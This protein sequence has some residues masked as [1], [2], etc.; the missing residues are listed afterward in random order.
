MP[1]RKIMAHVAGGMV[2]A[3]GAGSMSS[4]HAQATPNDVKAD[5]QFIR[6]VASTNLLEIQLGKLAQKKATNSAVK[7]FAQRM[8]VDHTQL[9]L[10]WVN[11]V[12]QNGMIFQPGITAAQQQEATQLQAVS[13][14]EFDRAYMSS[15]IQG[16]Q[17]A[18]SALQSGSQAAHSSV[19]RALATSALTTVQQHLSMASQVGSQVG[20]TSVATAT[21]NPTV[22][23]TNPNGPTTNPT[24]PTTNPTGP[25]TTPTVPT[26][27]PTVPT[28][29]PAGQATTNGQVATPADLKEDSKF[30]FDQ[31]QANLME[32]RL[33]Q[34]A[35]N[36]AKTPAVKRLAERLVAD[37]G[38]MQN[39]WLD[40]TSRNGAPIKPSMGKL[41]WQKVNRL[42]DASSK[43]F[44]RVYLSLVAEN[45][46]AVMNYLLKEGRA[47]HSAQVRSLVESDIPT[48]RGDM[49][50][51]EQT[52]N[53]MGLDINNKG[54][55]SINSGGKVKA[56][57]K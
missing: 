41:H 57:S 40:M 39:E 44:D 36:R 34:M 43:E 33:G 46:Q 30:I 38:R 29:N 10:Q 28:T 42:R 52:A 51:T 8:V 21:T 23:P 50:L 15:M 6:N 48:W 31:V 25:T 47:A 5:S 35:E 4:L 27:T 11:T 9:E 49:T 7:D 3:L 12:S 13:G 53:Q 24:L 26:T 55:V 19:V 20:A 18:V 2:I 1:L 45:N 17:T 16:H 14:P 32:V 54:Q 37:H 22:P 56:K